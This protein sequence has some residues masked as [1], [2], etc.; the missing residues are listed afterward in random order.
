VTPSGNGG[1][2][3]LIP[4]VWTHLQLTLLPIDPVSYASSLASAA[5]S[6]PGGSPVNVVCFPGVDDLVVANV[7]YFTQSL[8]TAIDFAR[9]A[10]FELIGLA[11]VGKPRR[12]ELSAGW[13]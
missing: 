7:D 3:G 1:S 4:S 9:R 11:E 12:V 8:E 6:H 2:S 10:L 5:W 13:M